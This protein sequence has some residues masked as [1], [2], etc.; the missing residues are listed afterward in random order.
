MAN[1]P[2]PLSCSGPPARPRRRGPLPPR[3]AAAPPRAPS[4]CSGPSPPRGPA[5]RRCGRATSGPR[6]RRRRTT[7]FDN[8]RAPPPA[9][10]R[11]PWFPRRSPTRAARRGRRWPSDVPEIDAALLLQGVLQHPVDLVEHFGPDVA[12]RRLAAQPGARRRD[13]LLEILGA[14]EVVV[15]GLH[16]LS[17]LL[18]QLVAG[19]VERVVEIL[20]LLRRERPLADQLLQDRLHSLLALGRVPPE[21]VEEDGPVAAGADALR[22]LPRMVFQP[23]LPLDVAPLG[24]AVGARHAQV[25]G[26][27]GSSTTSFASTARRRRPWG[28]GRT[29]R[30]RCRRAAAARRRRAPRAGTGPRA[31]PAARRPSPPAGSPGGGPG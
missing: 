27:G 30:R 7:R 11:S 12:Q 28:S 9:R 22:R 15:A 29:R 18:V 16:R 26:H 25:D 1:L 31:G 5:N 3:A 24:Q 10:C 23:A 21:L 8:R 14:G 2:A 17:G 19:E 6:R 13:H 4:P 20:R